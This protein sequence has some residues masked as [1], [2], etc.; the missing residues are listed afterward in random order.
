MLRPGGQLQA[1][2]SVG[3]LPDG[4]TGADGQIASIQKPAL[5]VLSAGR[6]LDLPDRHIRRTR[7]RRQSQAEE[8]SARLFEGRLAEDSDEQ[9][10][11][12]GNH[13]DETTPEVGRVQ[14]ERGD[15]HRD[16]PSQQ[17]GYGGA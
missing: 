5:F 3:T 17:N 13:V 7:R 11:D 16:L 12:S 10:T 15:P 1:D 8:S 2:P 9:E 14:K 4:R 6:A